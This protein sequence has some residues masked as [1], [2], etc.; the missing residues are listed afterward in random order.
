[1]SRSVEKRSR[2]RA[3]AGRA[4]PSAW[5]ARVHVFSQRRR[6]ARAAAPPPRVAWARRG[7]AAAAAPRH[8]PAAGAMA[9]RRRI[10]VGLRGGR[11]PASCR[12]RA[13]RAVRW[14]GAVR[15][16]APPHSPRERQLKLY[17]QL[18]RTKSVRRL[19]RTKSVRRRCT[20]L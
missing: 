10:P 18:S 17:L 12:P 1:M 3:A 15:G 7:G 11:L 19:S 20:R 6:G 2:V 5:M 13:R 14:C 9:C 8:R 4:G 16:G